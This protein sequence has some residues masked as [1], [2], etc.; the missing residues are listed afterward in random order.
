MA[1]SVS[2]STYVT[3]AMCK[4]MYHVAIRSYF[5]KKCVATG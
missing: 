2:E 5:N 4:I 1:N 3:T